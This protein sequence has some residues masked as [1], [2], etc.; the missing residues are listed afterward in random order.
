MHDGV[1]VV[2]ADVRGVVDVLVEV[3]RESRI[4]VRH[5]DFDMVVPV[6]TAL[7]VPEPQRIIYREDAYQLLQKMC[8]WSGGIRTATGSRGSRIR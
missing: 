4:D 2:R 1:V 3:V 8:G 7:L 6:G 5:D